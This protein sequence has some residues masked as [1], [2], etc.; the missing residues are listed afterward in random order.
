MILEVCNVTKNFGGVTAIKDT[1]FQVKAKEIYGLIGPNG[2]GK[3]TM[4]NIIT[5]NYE[6]THGDIKFH[7]QKINGIKPYKIVHRGIARTF[8]NIRL[9]TSM[10]VLDNVLIGFD[11]QASYSYLETIFRLP[12]FFKE[13]KRVKQRALEIME[14]LG[15]ADYA[16]ELA[17]SLSYGSQRK[18]EI[19]RALAAN[20]QLLLLDE[21][22]A[23]MNP[24]ET[25]ELA[26]LFFKIRDQFD[27]TILLIEHDMKFV[28]HL[29]D[30][31]MVL[32]YGKTIF[33]GKIEDAI[34]DEEVIKAYLGDFKH[35]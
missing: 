15:I 10:T 17:T 20:P 5:G 13:E 6:P 9:F 1:S 16:D 2:A 3:T 4:F 35:A 24:Q 33:E 18:V 27:I 26:K 34:K 8:Q 25:H 29:C 19:A 22:A 12:R 21:P 11:Y 28:N 23:G 14:V 31:V 7:G 30:R 32:D